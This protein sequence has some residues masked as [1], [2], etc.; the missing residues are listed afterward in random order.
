MKNKS[1][2]NVCKNCGSLKKGNKCPICEIEPR[3]IQEKNERGDETYG[4]NN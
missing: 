2:Q 4:K 3:I 1:Y